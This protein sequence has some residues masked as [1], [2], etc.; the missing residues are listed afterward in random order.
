MIVENILKSKGTKVHTV[1]ADAKIADA[2]RVL[3]EE[4]IGVVIVVDTIQAVIGI[5]SER[6]VIR[7]MTGDKNTIMLSPVSRCM[8][9]DP[10]TCTPEST[11]D[12]L[13]QIMT[14]RRIRHVPVLRD[15]KLVGL[16]SI[17]DVV[18]RKIEEAEEEVSA[19]RDYITS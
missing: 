9:K 5:L 8:T 12:E 10:V 2:V 6:D 14:R 18:K 3:N 11:V 16:V 7:H 15:G 1:L 13:M 17:G 19:M 4:N